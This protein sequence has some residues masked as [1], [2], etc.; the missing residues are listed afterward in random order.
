VKKGILIKVDKCGG[1]RECEAIC[2]WV[3]G[4]GVVNPR[5]GMVAVVKKEREGFLMPFLCLQCEEP[6]CK[7]VCPADAIQT[8]E[9]TGALFVDSKSCIGCRLCMISC[10]FGAI[11]FSPESRRVIKC[12]LC[13]DVADEPQCVK[14]CPKEALEYVDWEKVRLRPK[15]SAVTAFVKKMGEG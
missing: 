8:D 9:E 3:H 12:D 7:E 13:K 11:T 14:W 15:E 10:P 6:A 4:K 1:C 5:R 2:S